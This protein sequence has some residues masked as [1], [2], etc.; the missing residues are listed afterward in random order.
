MM[1]HADNLAFA[2]YK[3]LSEIKEK[4]LLRILQRGGEK[5]SDD[6]TAG[7]LSREAQQLAGF[8]KL[9][10]GEAKNVI[11]YVSHHRSIYV[12]LLALI[13]AGYTIIPIPQPTR[14]KEEGRSDFIR[15]LFVDALLMDHVLLGQYLL[16]SSEYRCES[17][18]CSQVPK[19]RIVQFTSGSTSKPK[20]VC[21]TDAQ[22]LS[23]TK[24]NNQD[25][26]FDKADVMGSWLPLHH[27]MG[28]FGIYVFSLV[29]GR[30]TVLM[31]PTDFLKKPIRWLTMMEK[32][33]VTVTGGPP[34]AFDLLLKSTSSEQLRQLNLQNLRRI[35]VGADIVPSALTETFRKLSEYCSIPRDA[36][37]S[38]YGL[39]EAVLYVCGRPA[40]SCYEFDKAQHLDTR[41]LP[42]I[43]SAESANFI[44]I[45]SENDV[46]CSSE[47]GE[48]SELNVGEIEVRLPSLFS[49]YL[50]GEEVE[51]WFNTG[52]LGYI[53]DDCLVVL[54]R[55]NDRVS[56]AGRNIY[57]AD[58]LA[59]ISELNIPVNTN[60][61]LLSNSVVGR[62]QE[63]KGFENAELVLER[64]D[65]TLDANQLLVQKINECLLKELG[66]GN[67]K[68]TLLKRG[69]LARTTSGKVTRGSK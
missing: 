55:N 52:D 46:Y 28:L 67:L 41:I 61:G 65:K 56:L 20:G 11:V 16:D 8:L 29:C 14:E 57:L 38:T 62:S 60:I 48:S 40:M 4:T 50:N 51:G 32:Y 33:S 10:F 44:R 18:V 23:N 59:L 12:G 5:G 27:D 39:A 31:S 15:S 21:L 42:C 30:Q 24:Y 1:N 36:F 25:W 49:N 37:F 9:K 22:I 45:K 69:S 2:I 34:F 19:N 13:Y 63:P 47:F 68:V 3:S 43:L 17:F 54:G 7:E 6:I 53:K 58:I 26:E 35:F 64:T 66:V